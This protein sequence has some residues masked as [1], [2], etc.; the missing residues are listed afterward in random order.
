MNIDKYISL[1][2]NTISIMVKGR[3][4]GTTKTIVATYNV[5]KLSL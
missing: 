5:V 1:G 2:K 3:A 4:T